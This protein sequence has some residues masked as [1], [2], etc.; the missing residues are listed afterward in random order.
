M[1]RERD[2]AGRFLTKLA[3]DSVDVALVLAADCSG[4]VGIDQLA[5]QF[6]GYAHAIA[7]EAF[8]AAVQSARHGRIALAFVVWTGATRQEQLVPWTLIDGSTAARRFAAELAEALPPIPG[9][10]SVSGAIDYCV[11]LF[12]QCPHPCERRVIDIS[13]DGTNNDG[14]N[15]TDARNAAVA[16]GIT[17]NGL[18][19]IGGQPN[20]ADYYKRNVIG[21]PAAFLTVARDI[22]SF[23]SAVLEK[24]VTEIASETAGR[25]AYA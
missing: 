16:A 22:A 13:G 15:V 10:T 12:S 18:P 6:H 8:T 5:L 20:I 2:V 9:Y 4:S 24:F 1:L 3:A 23:H 19:I 11:R 25:Q 7:S 14:R 21:G 17:I